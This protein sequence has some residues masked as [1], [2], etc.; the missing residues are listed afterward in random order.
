MNLFQLKN[1][2]NSKFVTYFTQYLIE[3]RFGTAKVLKLLT[4]AKD[5]RIITFSN[6]YLSIWFSQSNIFSKVHCEARIGICFSIT[7]WS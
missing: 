6:K 7:R 5:K 4:A 3:Q 1:N 2:I